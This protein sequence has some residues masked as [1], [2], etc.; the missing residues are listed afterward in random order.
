MD[1]EGKGMDYKVL[2]IEDDEYNRL[3]YG[4]VLGGK[5]CELFFAEDDVSGFAQYEQVKPDLILLDLRF[6]EREVGL[7]LFSKIRTIDPSV[8]VIVISVVRGSECQDPGLEAR[9]LRLS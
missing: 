6:G 7:D 2:I 4:E 3:L 8:E 1:T 9:G 5:G